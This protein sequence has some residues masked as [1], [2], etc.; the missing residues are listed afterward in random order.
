MRSIKLFLT[1]LMLIASTGS[2]AAEGVDGS[3][4]DISDSD[5][6]PML[7]KFW[8]TWCAACL[9]EMPVYRE[10]YAR[11][12]NAIRFIAVNVA[13]ND[14]PERVAAAVDKFKLEMPVTYDREGELWDRYGIIGTPAYILLDA[15]GKPVFRSWQHNDELE[16]ALAAMSNNDPGNLSASMAVRLE[17]PGFVDIDGKPVDL[18]PDG[19]SAIVAYRFATWCTSYVRE[20]YPELSQRCAEFN[21]RIAAVRGLA[22]P[23]VRV[24]GFVAAYSTGPDGARRFRDRH[25]IAHP[26]VFD[27]GNK[28]ASRYGSRS[29]PH[30]TVIDVQGNVVFSGERIP[31]DIHRIVTNAVND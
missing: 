13:V 2:H 7:L 23:R 8:A 31:P 12:G 29:F 5:G 15:N 28:Y 9:E 11:Y 17:D 22:G 3:S 4:I 25:D 19:A 30:L 14:P 16:A 26:L 27:L 24:V 18:D 20:S 1:V 10:A 6:R 21:D